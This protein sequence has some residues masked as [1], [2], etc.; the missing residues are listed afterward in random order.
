LEL[1]RNILLN[2]AYTT[3]PWLLNAIKI[4]SDQ[5][6]KGICILV[7]DALQASSDDECRFFSSD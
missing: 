3:Q 2:V 5:I 7:N 6:L 1:K 4:R